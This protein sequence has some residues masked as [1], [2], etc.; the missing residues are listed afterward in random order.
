MANTI[1]IEAIISRLNKVTE[2]KPQF[3]SEFQHCP[4]YTSDSAEVYSASVEKE[5]FEKMLLDISDEDWG[6]ILYTP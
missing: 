3:D 5:A 6:S 1:T 4:E 2:Y